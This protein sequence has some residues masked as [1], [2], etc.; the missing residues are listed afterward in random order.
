MDSPMG[1]NLSHG[2]SPSIFWRL[3][4]AHP[5]P[6]GDS[7]DSEELNSPITSHLRRRSVHGWEIPEVYGGCHLVVASCPQG[8]S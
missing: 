3:E 4:D 6:L 2:A 8:N 1:E 7:A 5:S